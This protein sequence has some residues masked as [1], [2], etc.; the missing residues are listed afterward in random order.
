MNPAVVSSL[1]QHLTDRQLQMIP[2]WINAVGSDLEIKS[3]RTISESELADHLPRLFNDLVEHLQRSGAEDCAKRVREEAR[4]HGNQRWRQGYQLAELLREIAIIRR[5]IMVEGLSSFFRLRPEYSGHQDD[6]RDLIDQ[7]FD[8]V[9]AGSVEQYVENFAIQLNEAARFLAQANERLRE[10]DK[11]RLSSIRGI[12]HDLGNFVNTLNWAV[13]GLDLTTDEN[14]RARL[15]HVLRRNLEDVGSLVHQLTDYSIL[16]AGEFHLELE[17]VSLSLFSKEILDSFGPIAEASG[18]MLQVTNRPG[19][20]SIQSDR[21]KLKQIISNLVS[22]SIKYR[23]RDEPGGLVELVFQ[24][25]NDDHWRLNVSDSGVGIPAEELKTIFEEFYRGAAI[26]DVPG[27]GLGL[28]ITQKLVLLLG[29]TISVS[30]EVDLG[31]QFVLTF[32]RTLQKQPASPALGE[33]V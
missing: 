32:P 3:A 6:A 15:L 16:L 10:I 2:T 17:E 1:A 20:E 13:E 24:S 30:S 4:K 8:N 25:Q 14:G 22:N 7:F 12:A 9:T 31:T 11:S 5:L 27:T 21:R 23:K 26:G 33:N 28:A 18:L 19:L 29:G